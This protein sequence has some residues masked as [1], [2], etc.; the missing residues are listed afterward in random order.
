MSHE[1]HTVVAFEKVGP[2]TLRVEFADA[3]SQVIDFRPVLK[4]KIYG[5]L[6]DEAI[7]DRVRLDAEARTLVWPTGAD[8]DPAILHDWPAR[9]HDLT[10]LAAKWERDAA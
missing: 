9:K 2:Y 1:I 7:F 4:G 8:F 6:R 3:T 10:R 5:P